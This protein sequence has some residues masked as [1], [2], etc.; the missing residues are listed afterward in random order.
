MNNPSIGGAVTLN[1]EGGIKLR[2]LCIHGS[3]CRLT[4]NAS[5]PGDHCPPA[6]DASRLNQVLKQAQRGPPDIP[7]VERRERPCYRDNRL[8]IATHRARRWTI[9]LERPL[10]RYDR[11]ALRPLRREHES[12]GNVMSSCTS[13]TQFLNCGHSICAIINLLSIISDYSPVCS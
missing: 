5:S 11:A 1:A 6:A 8:N 9:D 12:T 4:R 2:R 3:A 7:P 13:A 10:G